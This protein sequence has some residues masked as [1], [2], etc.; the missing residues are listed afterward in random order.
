MYG[1]ALGTLIPMIIN[2]LFIQPVYVCHVASIRYGEYVRRTARTL[3]V[4]A[5][6]LAIPLALTLRFAAP[7][8]KSLL[9][10]GFVSALVYGTCVWLFELEP[11]ETQ[12]LRNAILP[13]AAGKKIVPLASGVGGSGR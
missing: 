10:L 5:C 13:R 11:G 12:I 4:V 8:Y 6:S 9:A 7:N 3:A 1:V 2:K